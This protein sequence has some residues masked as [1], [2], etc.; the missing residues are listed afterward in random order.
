[1]NRQQEDQP[2]SKTQTHKRGSGAGQPENNHRRPPLVKAKGRLVVK[3]WG[4]VEVVVEA[5][6]EV[7]RRQREW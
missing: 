7:L 6:V 1:M 3:V 5:V 4:E 2:L